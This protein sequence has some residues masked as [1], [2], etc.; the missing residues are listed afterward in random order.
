[1]A[2][3]LMTITDLHTYVLFDGWRNLV[4]VELETDTGL[5]G[6]GEATLA[7]RTEAVLAYLHAAKER[8]VVGSDPFDTEALWRRIYLGD[9]IRGGM[10]A[11][12]ALSAID[13]ACHD[14][15]GKALGVPVYK[16]LGGTF[17]EAV[18][19][20]ANGWYTVERNPEAIAGRAREA[21]AR[22]YRGLKIDPFGAGAGELSR[23]ERA[24][25]VGIVR[26]VR[27]AVGP[28]VDLFIEAHGRF[29]PVEAIRLCR[30]LEPYD[31]GWFE[32]PCPWDD[33]MAWRE[34]KDKVGVPIAGGEHFCTRWGFRT[35]IEGRCVDVLQPDVL[36][37]G[38]VSEMR[39]LCAW[40]DAY[41]LLVAP[42]NS[43]GPVC[44]AAS[45]HV[46][47]GVPNLKV[48]EV[49]D[50]F[51]PS[52][53]KAAVPGCPNVAESAITLGERPGLGV[54]LDREILAAHPYTSTYFNLFS[55]GWERRFQ[56][57]GE[58]QP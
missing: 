41:S 40:A 55:E 14:I 34:V 27:E 47:R 17:R 58:T 32:E 16:L 51:M 7:N 18:P 22:G 12:A 39:K 9:F 2:T 19:C 15:Q 30:L 23:S 35:V 8:H 46:A 24:L 48:L 43:Q 5:T 1:M 53:V 45:A 26:A 3:A 49:F 10:I 38:G 29:A 21:V 25:S 36:Y 37:C 56:N 6:L 11:C 52:F 54:T 50:D 4:F 20:Y 42:H 31:V 57:E 28:D 44:T 13:I 33:P